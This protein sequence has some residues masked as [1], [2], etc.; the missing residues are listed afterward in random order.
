MKILNSLIFAVMLTPLV[1]CGQ[2]KSMGTVDEVD[3]VRSYDELY[4]NDNDNVFYYKGSN[5]GVS[6][7]DR[8]M[9][10]ANAQNNSAMQL[11]FHELQG[12]DLPFSGYLKDNVAT[13]GVLEGKLVNGKWD[14]KSIQWHKKGT[15]YLEAI[16][17][18]GVLD[19]LSTRWYENGNKFNES[20]YVNGV[21]QSER[22]WSENGT[23][24]SDT[25][26]DKEVEIRDNKICYIKTTNEK[27][28]CFVKSKTDGKKSVSLFVNGLPY[29]RK[30]EW[31][32][33]GTKLSEWT[34]HGSFD[35]NIST[36]KCNS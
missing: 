21:L 22:W 4:Y 9:I 33:S 31:Y 27:A 6:I 15:K 23:L 24:V 1:N 2:N 29:G 10:W 3:T 18:N 20:I 16:Y 11:L 7:A 17:I 30:I 34:Y 14:G 19:G 13:S 12:G 32:P 25:L 5:P 35:T 36:I 26:E 28:S 8:C